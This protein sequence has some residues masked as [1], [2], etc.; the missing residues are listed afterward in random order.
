MIPDIDVQ[1]VTEPV[2][3]YQ[4]GYAVADTSVGDEFRSFLRSN[5]LKQ[6][7]SSEAA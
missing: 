3:P 6:S 5:K 7:S 1:I 2:S 4:G